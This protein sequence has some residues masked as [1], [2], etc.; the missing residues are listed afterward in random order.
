MRMRRLMLSR[1]QSARFFRCIFRSCGGVFL[2]EKAH[3]RPQQ[4]VQGEGKQD[5]GGEDGGEHL[6]PPWLRL[7]IFE[8]L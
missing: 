7:L 6:V 2:A 3:D 5:G 1:L 4:R 8:L